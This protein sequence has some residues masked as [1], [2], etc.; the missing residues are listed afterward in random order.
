MPDRHEWIEEKKRA[1]MQKGSVEGG[2]E[3]QRGWL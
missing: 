3:G 2:V 1:S